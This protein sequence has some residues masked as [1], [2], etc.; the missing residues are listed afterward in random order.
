LRNIS[1]KLNRKKEDVEKKLNSV[2]KKL[3]RMN[4]NKYI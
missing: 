4:E 1:G 2:K 3:S